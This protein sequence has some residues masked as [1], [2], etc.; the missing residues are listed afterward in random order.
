MAEWTRAPGRRRICR[1]E[2]QGKA[3][4]GIHRV[5]QR[6]ERGKEG[7][8]TLKR[9]KSTRLEKGVGRDEFQEAK[10]PQVVL[11]R[12]ESGRFP[13]HDAQGGFMRPLVVIDRPQVWQEG[14]LDAPGGRLDSLEA[15][16]AAAPINLEAFGQRGKP[17]AR[18]GRQRSPH[19]CRKVC[20]GCIQEQGK[21]KR[22]G[23]VM[24]GL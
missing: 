22:G 6:P 23:G 14:V 2:S 9:I 19:L 1:V 21:G 3:W 5:K 11:E 13:L 10:A 8:P 20:P 12:L 17:G 18:K 15:D 24:S 16:G 7:L 4:R